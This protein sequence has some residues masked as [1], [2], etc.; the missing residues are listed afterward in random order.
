MKLRSLLLALCVLTGFA[1]AANAQD[2]TTTL[3]GATSSFYKVDQSG[4]V[5]RGALFDIRYCV[6]DATGSNLQCQ[7]YRNV[8]IGSDGGVGLLGNQPLN[9]LGILDPWGSPLDQWGNPLPPDQGAQIRFVEVA[10][11]AGYRITTTPTTCRWSVV[12]TSADGADRWGWGGPACERDASGRVLIR[13]SAGTSPTPTP[14]RPPAPTDIRFYKTDP[15]GNVLAGAVYD[16]DMCERGGAGEPWSCTTHSNVDIG[17]RGDLISNL[18]PYGTVLDPSMEYRVTM[19]EVAPPAGFAVNTVPTVCLYTPDAGW[20]R[21]AMD[22]FHRVTMVNQ[23]GASTPAINTPYDGWP[24]LYKTDPTGRVLAGEQFD[25]E[26]CADSPDGECPTLQNFDIPSEGFPLPTNMWWRLTLTET[27]APVGYLT[28]DPFVCEYTPPPG[29]SGGGSIF[30]TAPQGTYTGCTPDALGRI[31]LVNRPIP[32]P[33]TPAPEQPAPAPEQPAP[34]PAPATPPPAPPATSPSTAVPPVL[35][36]TAPRLVLSKRA[37]RTAYRAGSLATY[38]L[39]VR[40]TGNA[41]AARV[42]MCDVLPSGTTIHRAPG[43]RITRGQACWNVGTL[44][45]GRTVTK[46][47][48]VRIAATRRTGRLVNTATVTSPSVRGVRH[49]ARAGITVRPRIAAVRAPAVTG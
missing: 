37:L 45:P 46:R 20:S 15:S 12:G 47:I 44:N 33:V 14:T 8:D 30:A 11:P 4:V 13:N 1:S 40:N 27:L 10:A 22:A 35:A 26:V 36:A 39:R 28:A 5:L 19:T 24:R 43:A 21:C 2:G 18:S 31:N 16:V 29:G 49:R 23:P 42:V 32:A 41:A 9:R 34:A 48:T 7:W 3:R 25:L 17:D 38:T 6:T